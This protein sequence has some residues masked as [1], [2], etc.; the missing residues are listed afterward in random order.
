MNVHFG[1]SQPRMRNTTVT[2]SDIGEFNAEHR[3]RDGEVQIMTW[4]KRAEGDRGPFWL[5]DSECL[6][7]R[8]DRPTGETKLETKT[9][10]ML[11]NELE[12]TGHG[13][14]K[15]KLFTKK[16][17]Q[18]FARDKGIDLKYQ[19][20]VMEKGWEGQPKGLLQVLWERGLI[21]DSRVQ[22]YTKDGRGTDK[23]H[24]LLRMMEAC[25]DFKNELSA[26]Q[27]LGQQIGITVDWTP[28]FH[29]EMAGEGVEYSWAYAK[30]IYRRQGLGKKKSR[31]SFKKLVYE[32]TAPDILSPEQCRKF[33]R[34]AR[35]YICAYYALHRLGQQGEQANE[36][37]AD[38]QQQHFVSIERM[39]K[40]FS[41]HRSALS[42]DHGFVMA[43]VRSAESS[44]ERNNGVMG[45]S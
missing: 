17:L 25:S 34:R 24:S 5:S 22:Q 33:S 28:K 44:N 27:H 40:A 41:T 11:I 39:K 26:L 43:E 9:K 42:F 8:Q 12:A 37:V 29:C 6:A 10:K 23:E 38:V 36:G 2:Q 14:P 1:G 4:G 45:G 18:E 31:D 21:D 7:R 3:L 35:S 30:A 32:C 15:G 13:L 16:R 19:K 20:Q